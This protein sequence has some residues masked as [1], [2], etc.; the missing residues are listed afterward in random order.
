MALLLAS[1]ALSAEVY[2]GGAKQITLI[3]VDGGGVSI[4]LSPAPKNCN[5]G[6]QYR[7]HARVYAT[8][9]NYNAMVSSLLALKTSHSPVKGLWFSNSNITC[10]AANILKITLIEY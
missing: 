9:P 8:Y 3:R 5:G 4:A 10:D 2:E 1:S 6:S 7:M